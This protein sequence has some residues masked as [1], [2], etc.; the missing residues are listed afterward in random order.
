MA[1][2]SS[3]KNVAIFTNELA[4]PIKSDPFLE[5][6]NIIHTDGL[7]SGDRIRISTYKLIKGSVTEDELLVLVSV[8]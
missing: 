3:F 7:I 4:Y 5:V 6:S 1:N 8:P 2:L